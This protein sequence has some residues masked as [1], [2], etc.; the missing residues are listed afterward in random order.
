MKIYLDFDGV[1]LDTDS[2]IYREYVKIPGMDRREFAKSYDWFKL[3]DDELIIHDSLDMIKNSKYEIT[4]LSKIS[5]MN[6][7][8]AKIKYLRSKDIDININLV[9]VGINKCDAVKASG[10]VL[11]D[12]KVVNLDTWNDKG[13]I[14]IYFNKDNSDIDIHGDINPGYSMISDLRC[15]V[16]GIDIVLKK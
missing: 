8:Q 2:V 3:M 12:D 15:L 1:I 6:E 5:T 7:G 14:A 13:G 10:N 11:I 16:D 4:L 9:P